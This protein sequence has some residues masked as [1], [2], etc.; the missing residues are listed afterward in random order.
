MCT[1]DSGLRT[2]LLPIIASAVENDK[3]RQCKFDEFFPRCEAFS[4]RLDV[5]VFSLV[6]A[7]YY[8]IYIN[9]NASYVY[10]SSSSSSSHN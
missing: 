9:H 7:E 2:H 3:E 8:H 1:H 4:L 6:T 5:V 10:A